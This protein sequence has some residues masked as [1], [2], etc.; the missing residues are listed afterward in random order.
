MGWA[1]LID[2]GAVTSIAPSSFAPH[3]P[4]TPHSGQLVN[5]NGGEI[6]IKGQKM[7]TYVAHQVVMNITF[8]IVEDVLNPINGLDALHENAVQ[9]R[10][11]QSGKAYLQ[12]KSHKAV[13]DYY[14]N[15]YYASGLVILGYVKRSILKRDDP[16]PRIHHL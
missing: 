10:L 9:F 5:V 16:G 7:V 1:A 11:F 3:V 6:K 13:L 12:Q 8:L 15:H 4:I 14:K 2:S